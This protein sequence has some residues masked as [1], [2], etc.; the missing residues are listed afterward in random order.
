MSGLSTSKQLL[1]GLGIVIYS[2]IVLHS[3]NAKAQI[4]PDAT[5]PNNSQVRLQDNTRFIEG[6][7]QAAGNLFHSFQE[8]SVPT[9]SAAYFNNAT[10]I[11]NILTRVTGGS[12]SNIDGLIRTNGSANLFLINPNGIIFGQNARLDIGGSFAASTASNLKFLDGSE[13]SATNPQALSL[14]KIN[15]TPGVQWGASQTGATISNAGNLLS[16]Q[17]L[18]LVAD[19]LDLRGQLRAGKDLILQATD[20][21][22]IRDSVAQP[23]LAIAGGNLT[24]QGSKGIDIL[25]INNPLQTPF[26]SGGNL[27]LISD[28]VISGNARFASNGSFSIRSISGKMANFASQYEPVISS[29]GD[30]DIAANYNGASLLVESKGNIRLLGDIN[31]T[32]GNSA[33]LPSGATPSLILRSG[34]SNL[35]YEEA[36]FDKKAA[37]G[38]I[39]FPKGI[40]IAGNVV[41]QPFNGL[42]GNVSLSAGMG[43]IKTQLISTNGQTVEFSDKDANGGAI[44]IEAKGGNITTG[45]LYSYSNSQYGDASNAGT[46]TLNANGSINT[47]ALNSYSTSN[48]GNA[49]NGGAINLTARDDITV[50]GFFR[51]LSS[52]RSGGN[53]A[54]GGAVNVLSSLGSINAQDFIFSWSSSDSG[55]RA[56]NGGEVNLRAKNDITTRRIYSQSTSLGRANTGNGGAI[57]FVSTNGSIKTEYLYS[58]SSSQSGNA[59]NG[60]EINLSAKG[61]ITGFQFFSSSSSQSG[62]A[63]NGGAISLSSSNGNINGNR[64]SSGSSSK[65]GNAGNGGAINLLAFNGSINN[66]DYIASTSFSTSGNT[67][68]GGSINLNAG[69][70]KRTGSIYSV[71]KSGSG[72]ITITSSAPFTLDKS[73]IAS[74]TFGSGRGGDVLITSPSI[75]LTEGSQISASSHSSGRGGNITL[76]AA[77]KV[78]LSGTTFSRLPYIS[79][80]QTIAGIPPNTFLGGYI[81]TGNPYES[82]PNETFFPTGIFKLGNL[83]V[84]LVI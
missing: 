10:N 31:I 38:D 41:L 77:E 42:G 17:D 3:G 52:S 76:N 83:Q 57:S 51:T 44:S 58:F 29:N 63:S 27:S 35:A 50:T 30:V 53:S 33:Q 5:L 84:M 60:S 82:L 43:D 80:S 28:G 65:S 6:G 39:N 2:T 25:T 24:I 46:I 68:S 18:T 81:P 73:V 14:L 78:E 54:N 4:T 34:Q 62:N 15:V 37:N 47:G 72:D 45:D 79:F 48:F 11:Q 23:F 75:S 40:T 16:G 69:D 20:T 8:F 74:D 12:V 19:K 61:D 36:N 32:A 56:G 9:N 71:S 70:V 22:K 26:V 21:V 49:S 67:G 1:K 13:F 7:T 59:G 55:N 66:T 64:L